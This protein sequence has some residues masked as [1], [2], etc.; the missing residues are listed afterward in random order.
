MP[1]FVVLYHDCPSKYER[2]SH[3]DLM[4]ER[5][6]ILRTWA[7]ERLP[8]DWRT[9]QL[10]TAARYPDCASVAAENVVTA[11]LLGDHR[12]EYLQFEGPLSAVR[13]AVVRVAAGRYSRQ[14]EMPDDWH[15][16]LTGTE[17]SGVAVLKRLGSA[18]LS[19]TLECLSV[20]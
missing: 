11:T 15:I 6:E 4:L 7:L 19:W 16:T 20:G 2:P 12:R 8:C 5:G 9:V 1:R 13:G 17:L 18:G 3:W 14:L 10:L